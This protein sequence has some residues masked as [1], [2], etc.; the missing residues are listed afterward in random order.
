MKSTTGAWVV[1]VLR[2]ALSKWDLDIAAG[3]PVVADEALR[4]VAR[5]P[6]SGHD[7]RSSGRP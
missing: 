6:P 4:L 2:W 7:N 3:L 5:K 1:S